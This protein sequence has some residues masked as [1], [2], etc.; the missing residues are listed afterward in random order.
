MKFTAIISVL[1]LLAPAMAAPSSEISSMDVTPRAAEYTIN[2]AEVFAFAAPQSCK[3][4]SCIDVISEAV[5][6][7]KAIDNEDW[8]GILTC[9]KKKE[10]CGCAGCYN[11]LGDFLEKYGIC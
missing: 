11:K 1:A 3:I 8:K 10:L 2:E 6:I 7:V 5:C 4:L 9:A